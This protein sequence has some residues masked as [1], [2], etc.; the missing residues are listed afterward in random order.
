MDY[1]RSEF[2]DIPVFSTASNENEGE[3]EGRKY[4]SKDHTIT[5]TE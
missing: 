4:I 5:L 3:E 2:V 1:K